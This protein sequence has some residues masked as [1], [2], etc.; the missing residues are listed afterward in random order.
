MEQ[1]FTSSDDVKTLEAAATHHG[2]NGKIVSIECDVTSKPSIESAVS[3]ISKSE[4]NIHLLVSNSGISGPTS[5]TEESHA[6]GLKE[7]LLAGS[8][9]AEWDDTYRTNVAAIYFTTFAFLPLLK[10]GAESEKGF[11]AS[12]IN[13]SSV[14]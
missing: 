1:R 11:S 13:V 14:S 12:I 10:K 2:Q 6:E 4:K 7:D 8:E 5:K 3:T 9:F